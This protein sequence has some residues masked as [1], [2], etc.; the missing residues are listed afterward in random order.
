MG[1]DNKITGL[2]A[3]G[4]TV[5]DIRV[6]LKDVYGLQ[7][8]PDLISRGPMRCWMRFGS[9]N[10]GRWTGCLPSSFLTLYRSRSATPLSGHCFAMPCRVVDSHII[11]N[12]AV[13]VARRKPK[14]PRWPSDYGKPRRSPEGQLSAATGGAPTSFRDLKPLPLQATERASQ[15][16]KSQAQE[17]SRSAKALAPAK[18]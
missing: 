4:L 8:S 2:Y 13:Y 7:V 12:K 14:N 3:T 16:T 11:K 5:R 17:T 1:G 10:P 6:H 15:A 18:Q 9:G